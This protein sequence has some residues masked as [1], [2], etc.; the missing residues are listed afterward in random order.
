MYHLLGV[1]ELFLP[2][3]PILQYMAILGLEEDEK[4]E[5]QII[6]HKPPTKLQGSQVGFPGSAEHASSFPSGIVS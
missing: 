5:T 3:V 1:L 4:T 2:I 6:K